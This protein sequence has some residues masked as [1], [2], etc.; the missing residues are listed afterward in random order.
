MPKSI[1]LKA[2]AKINLCLD[3]IGTRADGYHLLESVMQSIELCDRVS[4]RRKGKRIRVICDK[5][6]I[7]QQSNIAYKAAKEFYKSNN[8]SE[9][10]GVCIRIKKQIPSQAGLGGGSADAAA[11]LVAL[12]KIF[13]THLSEEALCEIG[14]R[15]GADVPFCVCGGTRLA[16]GI[17]EILTKIDNYCD[18]K[19]VI[20][21]GTDGVS[22]KE[23]YEDFDNATDIKKLRIDKVI[24]ALAAGNTSELK[25]RLINVFEQTTR[26]KEVSKIVEE[27]KSLGAVEAAMTGSGSAVFGI[28]TSSKDAKRCKKALKDKYPFV[29]TTKPSISG[30]ARSIL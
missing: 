26:V 19:L 21:K 16:R 27:L 14:A 12:N 15:I 24:E 5:L 11:V 20:V 8:I 9:D 7:P 17:G 10:D 6:N 22:T 3:I 2:C 18:F 13:K 28:F 1:R 25:G 23:A 4:V 30:V 29:C